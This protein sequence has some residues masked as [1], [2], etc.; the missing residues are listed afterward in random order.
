MYLRRER[1]CAEKERERWRVKASRA[2]SSGGGDL[3]VRYSK[4]PRL[5]KHLF[6]HPSQQRLLQLHTANES[7]RLRSSDTRHHLTV[8]DDF[9]QQPR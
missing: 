5:I 9:T 1:E 6:L 4:L 2:D 7:F 3:S 8:T